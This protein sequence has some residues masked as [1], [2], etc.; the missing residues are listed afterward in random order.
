MRH[1][2]C[3]EAIRLAGVLCGLLA[4]EPT[5]GEDAEALGLWA[6]M[7]LHDSRRDARASSDGDIILLEDQDRRLWNRAQRDEGLGLLDAALALRQP[8]AYQIQAAIAALHAEAVRAEDTDWRQIA[9]L[10]DS[11]YRLQPSP[12][13]ALNR[14][15]AVSMVDGAERGLMMLDGL[16]GL[17]GYYLYHAAR[18]DLL[19]RLG[20]FDGAREAYHRAYGLCPNRAERAYLAR[21]MAECA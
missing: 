4:R 3:S 14:A 16:D 21:R 6:L 5:L 13:I 15:V 19:R 17:D 11:L 1:D 9:L 2:L 7:L 8:G 10:Y 20:I 12:I 18:A